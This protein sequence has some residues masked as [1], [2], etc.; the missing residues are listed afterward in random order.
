[1]FQLEEARIARFVAV[2]ERP[3]ERRRLA[4]EEEARECE[5]VANG[6]TK[7]NCFMDFL[8]SHGETIVGTAAT[9][10]EYG[11][12]AAT[13]AAPAAAVAATTG[14]QDAAAVEAVAFAGGCIAGVALDSYIESHDG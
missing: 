8:G 2:D 9:C 11:G 6:L 13:A 5:G 3:E 1:M 12:M 7:L 10:V 4:E 14:P